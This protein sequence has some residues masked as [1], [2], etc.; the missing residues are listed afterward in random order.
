MARQRIHNRRAGHGNGG[1]SWISYSDIMAALVMVFV[2][3]LVFNLYQYNSL[4]EIKTQELNDKQALLDEQQGI[5]IIQQN[6]L[7]EANGELAAAQLTLAEQEDK[8]Q[9]QTII[10][11]G[12]Q[13]ELDEA[14]ATLAQQQTELTALQLQLTEQA[15][16]FAAQSARLDALVGVRTTII[17]ALSTALSE[18][19]LAATVDPANGN[20]ILDSAVFF[21]TGSYTIRA[22]GQQML[23]E[24]LPVYLSVLLKDEYSDY[25][26]EIIIEGH[27]D[28]SGSY[29][30]NL[31]L[32][33]NRALAVAKFCLTMEELT[34]QQRAL[35]QTILVA[36]GKSSSDLVY[37]ADGTENK[38]ASRRVEFKF[39]L[40]DAE[41]IEEINQ[42]LSG[43]DG[44][45]E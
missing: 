40:K 7:D 14:K 22:E 16:A 8:L 26:G 24:F 35:L 37:N 3:F 29:L 10:L 6:A 28:S 36:Q 41:M 17:Q 25:L 32:S 20:I 2:L 27:T 44:G 15:E 23:R 5:L 1:A 13:L 30:S 18:S 38:D 39:S 11:I 9:Q 33:Q 43:G 4:L 42:I 45:N 12:Q 31:E 34:P 19:N 21:E